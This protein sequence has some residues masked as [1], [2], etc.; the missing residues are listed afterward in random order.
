MSKL[1]SLEDAVRRFIPD[2]C[3]VV[4]GAGL[5]ALI[6][7]ACGYE[8]V[9]QKRRGLTLVAPISDMLFDVL[10][11]AGAVERVIAAWVGNVSAGSGHNFR[12]AVEHS[13]PNRIQV[14]DH[15]NL[16]LA[17]ALHAAALGVPYLPARTALGTDLLAS[18]P[19]LQPMVCPF[20]GDRLVG[21]QALRPDVAVL[22]VQRADAEGNAH[23]IGNLGV[24]KDAARAAGTV[25]LLAEEIVASD[26]I[27]GE[28]NRT[29]VPGFLV[30]AVVHAPRGC[31]PSPC[32]GYY[33]RDHGFF[34]DY[35]AVSRTR[36]GFLAWLDEWVLSVSGH[37]D[38]L[39][40]LS[41]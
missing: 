30:S 10:I 24:V 20:T 37:D 27:C 26:L 34:H 33:D 16:T 1:T 3:T 4:L 15:S 22:A 32:Y 29:L 2:G 11:G 12:R 19:H 35:H 13:E 41:G 5:E 25:V 31:H 7:F 17:L 40:R 39:R 38:Y 21:V 28:P 18:N 36:E 9:R 6:P 14:V 8:I 23:V